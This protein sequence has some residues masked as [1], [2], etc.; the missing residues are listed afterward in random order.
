MYKVCIIS[1]GMIANS[2]HIPAYR[3]FADDFEIVAVSDI[4]ETAAKDTAKR[5]GID[6]YY[7]DAE[8]MLEIEKPDVVSVCVPNCFHKQY[9]LMA[10]EHGAN[11][12]C[13][14]PLAFT[15]ADAVQMYK[16]A[17]KHG[18]LLMACQS[19]RFTPDRLAA[20]K[21]I[22]D[23][24]MDE[25]YFAQLSR[26]R[27]RGIPTW[28]T[29][30]MKEI[31]CGGAFVDIGVHMLDALVWLMGNPKIVSVNGVA[32]VHHKDEIGSLVGSG[33]L[34]G[35][36]HN[37]RSFDP[38]EMN[39]EDFACGMMKFENGAAVNFEVAW[40]ANMPESSDIRLVSKKAG[41]D[42]PSGKIY[43]GENGEKQL[44]IEQCPYDTPFFGHMYLVDNL[45]NV[46]KGNA[47]PIVKA[48]ETINVAAILEMFYK[49]AQLNR[50]VNIEEIK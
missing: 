24:N 18:K 17:E 43:F 36:V 48:E 16:V 50:T 35:E 14:K 20:K 42:I 47:E 2:A 41:I 12:I 13:E 45:R 31:S 39:V 1:C 6:R 32:G 40:A 46:L 7:T 26:V 8:Q 11:V 27:R 15:R 33:A 22:D 37:K 9:A 23:G 25:I 4:N 5:N 29:F 38:A 21:F 10:L 34:T 28:G 19:M 3:Y 49:S 30:H 44:D